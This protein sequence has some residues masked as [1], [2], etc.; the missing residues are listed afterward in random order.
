M[1]TAVAKH[2]QTQSTNIAHYCDTTTTTV[3]L[4]DRRNHRVSCVDVVPSEDGKYDPGSLGSVFLP[5]RL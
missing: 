5:T 2:D 4:L 1:A 3:Q